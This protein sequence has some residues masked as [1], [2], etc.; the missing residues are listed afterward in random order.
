MTK[1]LESPLHKILDVLACSD[2]DV[3]ETITIVQ[4]VLEINRQHIEDIDLETV[5]HANESDLITVNTMLTMCLE[6]L[7]KTGTK[8]KN[9]GL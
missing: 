9:L 5:T 6:M 7:Q 8:C 4:A 3:T 2:C 1:P